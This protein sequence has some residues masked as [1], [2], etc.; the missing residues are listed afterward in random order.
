[1]PRSAEESDTVAA[2]SDF[3]WP[4]SATSGGLPPRPTRRCLK[5]K[6]SARG[7][8]V[9]GQLQLLLLLPSCEAVV[10]FFEVPYS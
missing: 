1:M 4:P 8:R 7:S 5:E 3:R 9:T 2:L 10:E 6:L